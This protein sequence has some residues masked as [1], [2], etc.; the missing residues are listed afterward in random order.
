MGQ[1]GRGDSRGMA[2]GQGEAGWMLGSQALRRRGTSAG[3]SRGTRATLTALGLVYRAGG[4][5]TPWGR[6]G[7]PAQPNTCT[8]LRPPRLRSCPLS[9][10]WQ[11]LPSLEEP[12]PPQVPGCRRGVVVAMG[13][14]PQGSASLAFQGQGAARPQPLRGQGES[15]SWAPGRTWGGLGPAVCTPSPRTSPGIS[16]VPRPSAARAAGNAPQ[17]RSHSPRGALCLPG[18]SGSHGGLDA[19]RAPTSRGWSL[20]CGPRL[21]SSRNRQETRCADKWIKMIK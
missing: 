8:L 21:S 10:R 9:G 1:G 7:V 12:C 5:V 17:T 6:Q 4:Q 11:P 13:P 15:P 19:A 14:G 18:S 16:P 2:R 20:T 3:R